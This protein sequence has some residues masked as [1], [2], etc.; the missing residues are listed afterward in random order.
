MG[1]FRV[2]LTLLLYTAN[3]RVDKLK[4]KLFVY[5]L[6]PFANSN[7]DTG[8]HKMM[9][10]CTTRSHFV[11]PTADVRQGV[12]VDGEVPSQDDDGDAQGSQEGA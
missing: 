1:V 11:G 6:K 12:C 3:R 2:K 10:P 7:R 9:L 4:L 8:L 5:K